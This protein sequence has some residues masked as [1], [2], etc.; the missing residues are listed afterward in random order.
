MKNI[1]SILEL[2]A[3]DLP[4]SR[5]LI[6]N[7]GDFF[8]YKELNQLANKI[9]NGLES[10]GVRRGDK[11]AIMLNNIPEWVAIWFGLTKIGG[12]LVPIGAFYKGEEVGYILQHAEVN[13]LFIESQITN[14]LQGVSSPYLKNVVVVGDIAGNDKEKGYLQFDRFIE[15]MDD[16]YIAVDVEPDDPCAIWYTSGTTR[17]PK[18]VLMSH[19]GFGSH[20]A[21]VPEQIFSSPADIMLSGVP[22]SS[23]VSKV[24][25]FGMVASRTPFVMLP[26]FSAKKALELI[27]SQKV[28]IFYGVPTMV[29]YLIDEL[30]KNPASYNLDS[31]R[32]II[33]SAAPQAEKDLQ[34]LKK[35]LPHV[36]YLR[37][38]GATETIGGMANTHLSD[39]Y[40]YGYLPYSVGRAVRG[41]EIKIVDE[42]GNEVPA[43][44]QGELIW[45]GTGMMKGYWKE[46][47]LTKKVLKNGYYYTGDLAKKD[48]LG[49][50]YITGRIDDVINCAGFKIFPKEVEEVL[51]SHPAV[52][53][54]AVVGVP[55]DV[56]G[57]IP[58]AWIVLKKGQHVS[59][60][61]L[62]DLC[63][64]QM[65]HYKA[66]REV[67][68]LDE[69]PRSA[70]GKVD[71]KKLV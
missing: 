17:L 44:E 59:E 28:T 36:V 7:D 41:S 66:P 45:R 49:M 20:T 32:L 15:A 27:Q 46:P 19:F 34:R 6:Y 60:K 14:V 55:D 25:I 63:R 48:E 23:I 18:G 33:A 2:A 37:F 10:L 64:S 42:Q 65:A 16:Q 47:E 26:R 69:I 31:L 62:I 21:L 40:M 4:D 35:L 39:Y 24:T 67:V 11:V 68:F 8:S 56:K 1:A 54:C 61:E 22:C 5:A 9:S 43:G 53:D 3:R 30:E 51:K 58:K 57:S 52:F 13:T 70:I 50:V 71:K 12:V 29:L 38:Y